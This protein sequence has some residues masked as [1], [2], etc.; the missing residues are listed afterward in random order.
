MIYFDERNT[1]IRLCET[2]ILHK[3]LPS[4][5][6]INKK[7][8]KSTLHS[9]ITNHVLEMSVN[10]TVYFLKRHIVFALVVLNRFLIN[11][12]IRYNLNHRILL[13]CYAETKEMIYESVNLKGVVYEP[14][15]NSFSFQSISTCAG[16][17]N[18]DPIFYKVYSLSSEQVFY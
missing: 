4:A 7:Q 8:G 3:N 15:Q 12:F 13:Y 14:K 16:F 10:S 11:L 9:L 6:F 1:K 2:V 17:G 18:V 5:Q